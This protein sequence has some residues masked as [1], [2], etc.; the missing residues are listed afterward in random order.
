MVQAQMKYH[1]FMQQEAWDKLKQ[2]L[3]ISAIEKMVHALCG[4]S[5]DVNSPTQFASV[6][7]ST[8]I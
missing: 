1:N 2:P 8:D 3:R 4:M 7:S 6:Q 5:V